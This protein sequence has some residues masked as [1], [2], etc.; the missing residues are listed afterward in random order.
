M[1]FDATWLRHPTSLQGL[2]KTLDM[3]NGTCL[4][5]DICQL[6]HI[7]ESRV[8]EEAYTDFGAKRKETEG[9]NLA[10]SGPYS[11]ASLSHE[12]MPGVCKHPVTS[13]L[14]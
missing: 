13:P 4:S 6:Q 3:I 5:H 1:E 14:F 8:W 7:M 9:W 10:H 11:W 2:R 12:C